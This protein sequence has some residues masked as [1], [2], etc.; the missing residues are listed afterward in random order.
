VSRIAR[1]CLHRLRVP[2][3]SPYALSI[4]L[5][6][7][8][9]TLLVEVWDDEGRYGM[10]EATVLTGYTD[11]TMAQ[12]WT[13]AN[14][15]AAQVHYKS[16][17]EALP[18]FE[19]HL[20]AAPFT[21]TAL[22]TAIE[23]IEHQD[24]LVHQQRREVELVALIS[25]KE[26]TELH[27][28]I[29]PLLA[30][31]YRV[32]KVKVGFEVDAD[33]QRLSL[34]QKVLAGRGTIRVDANQGYDPDQAARFVLSLQPDGIELVEQTCAAHDWDAARSI[35]EISP[36]PMML[37][38][39]I[40]GPEDIERAAQLH[41]ASIIK[42][43]LMKAGG[44]RRLASAIERIRELGMSPLLG[45]GVAADISCWMEACVASNEGVVT[46]GEMNGFLKTE[47]SL[48]SNPLQCEGGKMIIPGDYWPHLDDE[49][50]HRYRDQ[51]KEWRI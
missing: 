24:I 35:A 5:I 28:E 12:C 43:K 21:V 45:N 51:V 31:G 29:E 8:F 37:D 46:A 9:D 44:L 14:Q 15:L 33:L 36:L 22:V 18:V 20:N 17:G 19:A 41:A 26:E 40:Y 50:V 39:S 47:R 25:K 16:L 38:E 23:M 10:G 7:A 42:F 32:F 48:F 27:Q 30:A 6:E 11:E 34:I 49:A 3:K 2:L 4:T 13:L 1:I